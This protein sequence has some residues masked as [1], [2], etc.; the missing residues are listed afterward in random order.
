MPFDLPTQNS[1]T[2]D[3]EHK[4]ITFEDAYIYAGH[5][6]RACDTL[7]CPVSHAHTHGYNKLMHPLIDSAVLEHSHEPNAFSSQLGHLSIRY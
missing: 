2:L 3:E 5:T 4:S 6:H 1:L 7:I